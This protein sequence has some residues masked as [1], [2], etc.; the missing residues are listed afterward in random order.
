MDNQV[1]FKAWPKIGRV[2]KQLHVTITEKMDG[3]NACV[4]VQDGKVVGVQS[5]N[6]MI[7]RH[8][9][10]AGFANW[11]YDNADEI[12]SLLGEGYHYGE[13]IGPGIQKNPHKFARKFFMLFNP[14]RYTTDTDESPWLSSSLPMGTVRVLYQGPYTPDTIEETMMKLKS[15]AETHEYTPEG[16][17]AYIHETR[18]MLKCTFENSE[19]KWKQA[20]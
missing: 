2:N 8:S 6:R 4:I 12:A 15:F 18:T 14:E 3:T 9:D 7:D 16:V 1:E 13:W 5:R 10:N 11:V 17:I 20:A 19:G